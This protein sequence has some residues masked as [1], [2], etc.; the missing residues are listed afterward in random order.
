[1]VKLRTKDKE[2]GERFFL[3]AVGQV[4]IIYDGSKSPDWDSTVSNLSQDQSSGERWDAK[5]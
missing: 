3:F 5:F 2:R 4:P 1:M